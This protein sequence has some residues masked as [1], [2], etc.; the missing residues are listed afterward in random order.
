MKKLIGILFR[1]MGIRFFLI[2][3]HK[4]RLQAAEALMKRFGTDTEMPVWCSEQF[5]RH[6]RALVWLEF[7]TIKEF[8]LALRSISGRQ[9]Y[10]RFFRL[11][12]ARFPVGFWSCSAL[13]RRVSLQLRCHRSPIGRDFFLS[14]ITMSPNEPGDDVSVPDRLASA[15]GR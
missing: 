7:L 10:L 2:R 14:M 6:Q 8:T 1:A 13:G 4:S 5:V 9:P 12:K 3:Y 15:P 11:M